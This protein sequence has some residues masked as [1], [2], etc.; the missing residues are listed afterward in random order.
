MKFNKRTFLASFA[1]LVLFARVPVIC[2]QVPVNQQ[3]RDFLLD[4]CADCHQREQ[5]EGG[6]DLEKL[7]KNLAKK[8]EFAK[9]ERVY[10]RLSR[11]EMPPP[12]ADA[13]EAALRR[14]FLASLE[15]GLTAA[16]A[17]SKGTRLRRLNRREYENTL[18]DLL[19]I[20]LKLADRL[21]EDGRSHEFDN[22]GSALGLSMVHMQKYVETIRFALDEAIAKSTRAPEPEAIR[23]SYAQTRE[24]EK[25]LGKVWKELPDGA[26]VRFSG[27]GYPSGMIRSTRVRQAGKYRIRVTGYAYQSGEPI[28]FSVGGTTFQRGAELPTFGNLVIW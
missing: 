16:H 9:W 19:G 15:N 24:A 14:R 6:F 20:R 1:L 7:G 22:I 10:D 25:F 17:S 3:S 12:E 11:G 4:H 13:P 23:G 26:V 5:A 28:T 27:G 21:P 18:N 8:S 2:A